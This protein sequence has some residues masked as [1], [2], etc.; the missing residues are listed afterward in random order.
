MYPKLAP[1][2]KGMM[3]TRTQD[4]RI[5]LSKAVDH[6]LPAGAKATSYKYD[7]LVVLAN[8]TEPMGVVT[9]Y[10]CN[11]VN[12]FTRAS[13]AES[14]GGSGAMRSRT[15]PAD[16]TALNNGDRALRSA[17]QFPREL[18]HDVKGDFRLEW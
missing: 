7:Y 16:R 6:H 17:Y 3:L 13:L 15:Y 14:S 11:P 18:A 5:I 10:T 8:V 9:T 4:S 1:G 2:T 12:H